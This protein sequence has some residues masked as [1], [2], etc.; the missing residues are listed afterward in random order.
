MKNHYASVAHPQSNGQVE[1]TN[2]T[3]VRALKKKVDDSSKK[4]PELILEILFG[5]NTTKKTATGFS[6]FELAYGCEAVLPVEIVEPS[7][8]RL[9]H[10][11]PLNILFLKA[12]LDTIDEKQAKADVRNILY[13]RRIA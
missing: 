9:H 6:L 5:Y 13:K 4:W 10:D 7:H 8:R 3:L 11:P 1:V 12:A 2:R